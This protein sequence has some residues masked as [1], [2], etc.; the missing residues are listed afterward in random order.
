MNNSALKYRAYKALLESDLTDEQKNRLVEAGIFQKIADFFGAGKDVLTTDLKKIFSNN[1]YNRRAATAK[2]NIEKEIDELKAIAKDAG[3]SE[4]AVYDM[5]NLTLKAK[6]VSPEEVASP[7]KS[8]TGGGDSSSGGSQ[9]LQPGK[10]VK[11]NVGDASSKPAAETPAGALVTNML[12]NASGADPQKAIDQAK[13]KDVPFQKAYKNLINKVAEESEEEV[14]T[15]K[16]VL[17]WLLD[18]EKIV[19]T[20]KVAFG[21]SARRGDD[22]IF[23]RWR[24]LAGVIKEDLSKHSLD[25]LAPSEDKKG[26]EDNSSEKETGQEKSGDEKSGEDKDNKPGEDKKPGGDVATGDNAK[27]ASLISRETK[28]SP[29]IVGPILNALVQK[30]GVKL[31]K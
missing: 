2:K 7:P 27:L 14:V 22:L 11:A 10:A 6:D 4:E 30:C 18:N 1:K 12:A 8:G 29:K 28:V 3:V 9:Q 15:V 31:A 23:E 25:E 17:D 16:K 24:R 20:T 19:P 26:S 13:E 21:E 5:L